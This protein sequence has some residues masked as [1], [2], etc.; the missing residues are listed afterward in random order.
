LSKEDIWE[1]ICI[2]LEKKSLEQRRYGYPFA[3][4]FEKEVSSQV[5]SVGA[6]HKL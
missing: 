6:T 1:P 4:K 5:K 3:K 2:K